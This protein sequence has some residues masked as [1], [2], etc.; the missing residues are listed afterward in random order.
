MTLSYVHLP[1]GSQPPAIGEVEPFKA[2]LVLQQ[3]VANDWQDQV[4]EWLVRSGCLYMMAWGVE[5]SSWDDSVDWANH[6]VTGLDDVP[7]DQFVMTTW[8]DDEPLAEVFWY[9]G[10]TAH[11][12]M[13]SL[14]HVAIIDIGPTNREVEMLEA[15]AAAQTLVE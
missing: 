11:H 8:H 13:V 12:P 6:I 14:E 5:C 1:A 10:F 4:S 3:A 7:D 2:V 9:A 15:Y